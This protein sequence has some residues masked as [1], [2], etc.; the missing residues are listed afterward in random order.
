MVKNVKLSATHVNFCNVNNN[1]RRCVCAS[2]FMRDTKNI[3]RSHVSKTA[4]ATT[5]LV[6]DH[7]HNLILCLP[8][9]FVS[10]WLLFT[11]FIFCVS[12]DLACV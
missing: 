6:A 3:L 2:M 5:V 11:F 12:A 10:S 1:K 9:I 8:F 4:T 7:M